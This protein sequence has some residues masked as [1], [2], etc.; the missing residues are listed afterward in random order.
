ML[1][2]AT[3]CLEQSLLPIAKQ[4]ACGGAPTITVA[5]RAWQCKYEDRIISTQ[6]VP[7]LHTHSVHLHRLPS[8]FLASVSLQ[9]AQCKCS[10][11]G[12]YIFWTLL[13]R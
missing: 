1:E 13:A 6:T 11:S 10:P 7:Q 4:P 9:L 2:L 12:W 8:P 3:S 5:K